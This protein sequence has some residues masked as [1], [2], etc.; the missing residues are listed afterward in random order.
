MAFLG[1]DSFT[2]RFFF[3]SGACDPD[4]FRV[5][6]F[7][8]TEEISRPYRFEINLISAEGE[9]DLKAV[10]GAPA[11]LAFERNEETRKIHGV[12]AEFDQGE[13]IGRHYVYRAVLVPRVWLMSLRR[14]S[15][16]YTKDPD[17][18]TGWSDGLTIQEILEDELTGAG[19][20]T[21]DFEI[22]LSEDH[23]F[24]E[25]VAQYQESDLDF[26]S[27]L[28]EH[29]GIFY[30]F[31]HGDDR[32]KLIIAD[33]NDRFAP[34][35]GGAEY[36]FRPPTGM[37]AIER[38]V[39][40]KMRCRQ[41]RIPAEVKLKDY[42]W[43]TPNIDLTVT[44]T[45]DDEEQGLVCEYGNHYKES[46]TDG[47]LYARFRAE[48]IR[49]KQTRFEGESNILGF[50]SGFRYEL[51]EHFRPDFDQEYLILKVHH[52]GSQSS[53]GAQG[54]DDA[55]SYINSFVA[56]KSDVSFRPARVTPKPKILGGVNAKVDSSGDGEFAEI[57]EFGRYRVA[58]AFDQ[59]TDL[60]ALSGG[61]ASR[62]IRKAQPYSGGGYG[63]HFPLHKGAEVVVMHVGGDPD[64]PVI[65]GAV[66]NPETPTPVASGN[67]RANTI[68]TS[69]GNQIIMDDTPQ[70]EGFLITNGRGSVRRS[71]ARQF[72]DE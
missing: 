58:L 11:F 53:T 10:N 67:H 9:I 31:E 24:R 33:G 30:Y 41:S 43:R 66:A 15:Q 44:E 27:R 50:T 5:V 3:E 17:A 52:A 12:L 34:L 62:W 23:P 2:P 71:R 22:T 38:E 54:P 1:S 61:A 63:M 72:D 32:E 35:P 60:A 57:D 47:A 36:S 6:D 49:C 40:Q 39:V 37:A 7:K 19:F 65:V 29:E 18:I 48:E 46:D 59:R 70:R 20:T 14:Q 16:I 69:S 21:D 56:I 68:R 26:I 51:A 55:P 13:W 4:T 8:G 25:Y 64:R 42:N 28:M 45:V